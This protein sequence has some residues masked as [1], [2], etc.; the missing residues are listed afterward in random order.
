MSKQNKKT[1]KKYLESALNI[2]ESV[3]VNNKIVQ[4]YHLPLSRQTSVP[5]YIRDVYSK[6]ISKDKNVSTSKEKAKSNTGNKVHPSKAYLNNALDIT[7]SIVNDKVIQDKPQISKTIQKESLKKE[8]PFVLTSFNSSTVQ[9]SPSKVNFKK[10][11]KSKT[12]P[13]II[14]NN[15]NSEAKQ[16]TVSVSDD[17]N[18]KLGSIKTEKHNQKTEKWANKVFH[19]NTGSYNPTI[20]RSSR[21]SSKNLSKIKEITE[22][23]GSSVKLTDKNGKTDLE[24]VD[25]EEP[26]EKLFGISDRVLGESKDE[27]EPDKIIS[28]DKT[29]QISKDVQNN[30][31]TTIKI[32]KNLQKSK[33][34]G[35]QSDPEK[36]NQK[37]P[38]KT[39]NDANEIETAQG[40]SSQ[41]SVVAEEPSLWSSTDE[42]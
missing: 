37:V 41:K 34:I 38:S 17:Y 23:K 10:L 27:I 8:N 32:N 19:E 26:E 16:K 22:S 12:S 29:H 18:N 42:G 20:P 4:S 6:K 3:V 39:N 13:S 25:S 5:N 14:S 1:S 36:L 24:N 11:M 28:D 35:T 21:S 9:K 15:E 30:K 33:N 31:S 7:Y 40:E 2:T